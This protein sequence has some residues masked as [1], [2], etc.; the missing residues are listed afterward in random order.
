MQ[1][2]TL[3]AICA[4]VKVLQQGLLQALQAAI[5]RLAGYVVQLGVFPVLNGACG[6]WDAASAE[7][8]Q[9]LRGC[10]GGTSR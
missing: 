1:W 7:P 3:E 4:H 2:C 5:E 6:H 9:S 8:E 10:K